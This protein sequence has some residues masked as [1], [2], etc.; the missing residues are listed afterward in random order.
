MRSK[1]LIRGIPTVENGALAVFDLT[2][3]TH[4]NAKINVPSASAVFVR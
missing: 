4:G 1:P 2:T 3:K